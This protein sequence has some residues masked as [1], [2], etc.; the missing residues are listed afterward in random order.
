M[1]YRMLSIRQHSAKKNIAP[2]PSRNPFSKI[3]KLK[4]RIKE[5]KHAVPHAAI[6]AWNTSPAVDVSKHSFQNPYEDPRSVS[7]TVK[8]ATM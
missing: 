8:M 5:K 3:W 1:V 6:N 7:I 4:N 2:A